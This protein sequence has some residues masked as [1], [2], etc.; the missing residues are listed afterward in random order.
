MSNWV[1][2]QNTGDNQAFAACKISSTVALVGTGNDGYVFKTEDAGL[3]WTKVKDFS[4]PWVRSLCHVDGNIVLAGT[5]TTGNCT[6]QRSTD[7]G[8]N[9]TEEKDLA[10]DSSEDEVWAMTTVNPNSTSSIVVAGTDPGA[11]IWR[12]TDAGDTWAAAS[13]AS[14]SGETQIL[15]MATV[16]EHATSGVVLLGTSNNAEIHRSTD[17]GDTWA[18]EVDIADETYVMA[19]GV[20][21]QGASDG[22]ILAGTIGTAEIWKSIDSGDNWTRITALTGNQV[23]HIEPISENVAIVSVYNTASTDGYLYITK[24]AGATYTKILDVTD[25]GWG[26]YFERVIRMDDTY[27][28]AASYDGDIYS[29]T[30]DGA[31]GDSLTWVTPDNTEVL[32][33]KPQDVISITPQ[34]Q[35]RVTVFDDGSEERVSF[36]QKNYYFVDLVWKTI[37]KTTAGTIM[38]FYNSPDKGT[39]RMAMFTRSGLKQ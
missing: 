30:I 33:T 20:L 17:S 9:W 27:Y 8:A 16:Y 1:S 13:T 21:K 38:D 31:P 34:R 32:S 5:G 18:Q 24:D 36:S 26:N 11:E 12:S 3:T 25:A 23:R 35:Q 28:F 7:A 37:S 29:K 15:C 22:V 19:F 39:L 4:E 2:K 10:T 6:I 14:V